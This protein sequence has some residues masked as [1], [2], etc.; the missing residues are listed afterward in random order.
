MVFFAPGISYPKGAQHLALEAIVQLELYL[1]AEGTLLKEPLIIK[2]S[3]YST[4]DEH[5]LKVFTNPNYAKMWKFKPASQPYKIQFEVR[6]ENDEVESGF[7]G[8]A[9]YL[10]PEEGGGINETNPQ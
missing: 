4:I 8:E 3:G 9:V 10:S 7:I 6:F 2:S 5:C 1:T